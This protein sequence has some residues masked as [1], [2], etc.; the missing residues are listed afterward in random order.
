MEKSQISAQ[1]M[2]MSLNFPKHFLKF[3]E[4]L[5]MNQD[6][7]MKIIPHRPPMLLV[8]EAELDE[9]GKVRGHYHVRGDEYFLQGHFP[10]NPVVPGVILCEMMAQSCAA[11]L[12]R[13][14]SNGTP[15][16]SGIQKATFRR[17]VIPG[18]T[19]EF[20]CTLRRKMANF[21]FVIGEGSV[22]GEPCVSGEF[23]FAMVS[24]T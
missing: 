15:Y 6:A 20:V 5:T 14:N 7:L 21:Y 8:D 2:D 16:F 24:N 18:E 22:N 17:K 13:D 19:V 10:G 9:D 12:V 11:I 23:S 1:K 3:V 4:R